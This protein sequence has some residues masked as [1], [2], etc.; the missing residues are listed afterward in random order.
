MSGPNPK[1]KEDGIKIMMVFKPSAT[2]ICQKKWKQNAGTEKGKAVE[3]KKRKGEK[4]REKKGGKNR[5][6]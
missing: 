1:E 6:E 5:E 2:Q 3:E 4:E